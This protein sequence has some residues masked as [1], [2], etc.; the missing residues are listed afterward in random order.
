MD[1]LITTSTDYLVRRQVID[2][3]DRDI[4]EYGFHALYNNII[5]ISS[6][7]IISI[8]LGQVP[9]SILYHL[10]FVAIRQSA[11]GFHAKTHL[12]CFVMSTAIWL[13]SLWGIS[14][15]SSPAVCIALAGVS[16]ILVWVKAP[17]EHENSPMDY[18]KVKHMQVLSRILS[19]AFFVVILFLALVMGKS[20]FWITGSLAYGMASHAVLMLI[21]LFMEHNKR[22]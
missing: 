2:E 20:H 3:D 7:V 12:R 8:W 1:K 5:D 13:L 19:T 4:Y 16:L 17:I 9:Q 21:S 15:T 22:V 10:S 18:D 11:G 14:Q 6:I